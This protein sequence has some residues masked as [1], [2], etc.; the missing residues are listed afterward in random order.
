MR[1]VTLSKVAKPETSADQRRRK[2]DQYDV[3][4]WR[5][6][7]AGRAISSCWQ[8]AFMYIVTIVVESRDGC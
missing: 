2:V 8:G 5:V 6:R 3:E 7:S 1:H 4:A